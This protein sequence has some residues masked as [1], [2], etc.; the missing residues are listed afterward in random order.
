[1]GTAV[2][3]WQGGLIIRLVELLIILVPVIGVIVAAMKSGLERFA[4]EESNP[5]PTQVRILGPIGPPRTNRVGG[6]RSAAPSKNT[7]GPTPG[8]WNTSSIW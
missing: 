7:I 6:E 5:P 2:A 1:M 8:G 4:A 3:S